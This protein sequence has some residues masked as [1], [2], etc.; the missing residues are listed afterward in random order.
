MSF[1]A[2]WCFFFTNFYYIFS[3]FTFQMLSLFL[4]FPP[5]IPNPFSPPSAPQPTHSHFWSW[6][7]P[8]LGHRAFTG[9][10]AF[11]P[12]DDLLGHPLLHLQLE[13]WVPPYVFLVGGLVPVS[14]ENWLVHIDVPSMGFQTPSA[15]WV[16]LW[17]LHWGMCALSNGWLS[18]GWLLYL[19]GTGRASMETAISG[20]CQQVLV[21]IC[22]V[23]GFGGCLWGR[24]PGRAVSGWSFLQALL[25]TLSL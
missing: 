22:L 11:P 25:R 10:R 5:K 21:G 13:P 6:H 20:S 23:S 14:T 3:L 1:K 17:L 2:F 9:P 7:S 19:S 16:F 24:S 4:V 18:N 15:P 8:I 12:I